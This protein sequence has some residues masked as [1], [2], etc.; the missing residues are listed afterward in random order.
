MNLIKRH[1]GLALICFLTLIL[2][3]IMFIIFAKMIFTTGNSIYGQ[4][5]NGLV[6]IETELTETIMKEVSELEEVENIDIR[7]QGKI[8]YT[9]ITFKEGTKLNKAKE[10]AANTL[11]KYSD[12]I[13]NYY[14]FGY[15]LKENIKE[16]ETDEKENDKTGFVAAGTKH[17][18]NANISW[19]K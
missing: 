5:L 3:I 19:T 8:V 11:P 2:I 1:K 17:P 9:T 18:D 13:I 16:V 4:R 14:D 15:F 7:I 12:D 6:K 10:I